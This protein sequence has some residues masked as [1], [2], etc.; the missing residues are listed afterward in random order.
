MHLRGV[1]I[2]RQSAR[3]TL[4]RL[5]APVEPV[6]HNGARAMGLRQ[7]GRECESAIAALERVLVAAEFF[8]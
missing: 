6:K 8:Q 5:G 3:A 2:E 7:V 1:G 4:Q